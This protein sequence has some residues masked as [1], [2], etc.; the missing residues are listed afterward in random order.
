MERQSLLIRHAPCAQ[1]PRQNRL[2]WRTSKFTEGE[3]SPQGLCY[4]P[5]DAAASTAV[6]PATGESAGC[7]EPGGLLRKMAGHDAGFKVERAR[8]NRRL[9]TMSAGP[10]TK[11]GGTSVP[12]PRKNS[13]LAGS[14]AGRGGSS[15]KSIQRSGGGRW[16]NKLSFRIRVQDGRGQPRA[17][18][19]G[20]VGATRPA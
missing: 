6:A 18:R 14:A 4:Q 17:N 20:E 1:L 10:L 2:G 12:E 3:A 7:E 5:G 13:A 16:I 15:K 19:A 9:G 11:K 8:R